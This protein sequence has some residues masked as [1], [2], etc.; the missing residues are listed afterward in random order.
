MFGVSGAPDF[1]PPLVEIAVLLERLELLGGD[2]VHLFATGASHLSGLEAGRNF[3][4][5]TTQARQ[6]YVIV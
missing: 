5:R 1:A 6:K 2:F 4:L 3:Q